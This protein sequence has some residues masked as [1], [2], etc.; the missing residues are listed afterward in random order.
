MVD[1]PITELKGRIIEFRKDYAYRITKDNAEMEKGTFTYDRNEQVLTLEATKGLN[2]QWKINYM[3]G[4]M[5]W[6]GTHVYGNN[7]R[8][9]RL[10]EVK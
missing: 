5:I 3:D 7:S 10:Y 9:M 2:S 4:T 1:E 8:Q 6:V